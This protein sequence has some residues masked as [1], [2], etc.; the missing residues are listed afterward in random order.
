MAPEGL[1]DVTAMPFTV[2]VEPASAVYG[3]TVIVATA[4][5]TDAV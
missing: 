5:A 2:T 1:A 3:V 4:L